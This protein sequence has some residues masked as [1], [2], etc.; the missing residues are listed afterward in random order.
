MKVISVVNTKGGTGKSTIA[1]N[2]ATALA[3]EKKKVLLIDT[4]AKQESSLSFIQIR[5]E[6][7]NLAPV[8]CVAI[9]TKSIWKDIK[10]YDNFDYIVIDAG[11]GDNALVRAAILCS[12]YGMLLIPVQP[13]AY[14]LWATEDTLQILEDCRTYY[15]DFNHNYLLLNRISNNA[16]MH[17]T[18]ESKES[19]KKLCSEYDL[20]VLS[21]ELRDRVAYKEAV[22]AGMNVSEF[23]AQ[24]KDAAKASEELANLVAEVKQILGD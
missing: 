12:L 15:D 20:K 22:I 21:T 8:S 1:V 18:A 2:L 11:A 4:D 14:D 10:T 3:Q 17:I 6:N 7:D 19:L 13:A 5:N 24:K 16:K 9:P 23:V